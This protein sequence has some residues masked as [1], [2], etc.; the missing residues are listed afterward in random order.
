MISRFF[1]FILAFS[2]LST[3]NSGPLICSSVLT[4]ETFSSVRAH[5]GLP[6]E[7]LRVS[8][9]QRFAM[10]ELSSIRAQAAFE[11][12]EG[13]EGRV[14]RILPEG[15]Q[16]PYLLKSFHPGEE[17]AVAQTFKAMR[18]WH[19]ISLTLPEPTDLRMARPE[20]GPF[21]HSLV[22]EDVRGE[23]VSNI[24][25]SNN[26]SQALK[27]KLVG[28]L[29][30]ALAAFSDAV[31]AEHPGVKLIDCCLSEED[32]KDTFGPYIDDIPTLYGLQIKRS[33]RLYIYFS[34]FN[35][36]YDRD[37]DVFVMIDPV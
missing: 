6:V 22:F 2:A 32:F 29:I 36:I 26:Y 20:P 12:G 30:K 23:T 25:R 11:L 9:E 33:P 8:S 5:E 28:K 16:P 34:P 35:I 31:L 17:E 15:G 7:E 14:Y 4:E 27:T 18:F 1:V 21:P 10:V 13:A 24:L 19:K 37:N 3:A